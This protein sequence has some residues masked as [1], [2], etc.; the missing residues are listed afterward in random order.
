MVN[1]S[2]VSKRAAED[3]LELGSQFIFLARARLTNLEIHSGTKWRKGKTWCCTHI[4]FSPL[5][6]CKFFDVG[7]TEALLGTPP[8]HLLLSF[9]LTHI[10]KLYSQTILLLQI[11]PLHLSS[12]SRRVCS[13]NVASWQLYS[14]FRQLQF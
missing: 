3:G 8:L 10:G 2:S 9:H 5:D 13:Q 6:F 4:G 12:Y 1:L 14:C 7:F 11:L